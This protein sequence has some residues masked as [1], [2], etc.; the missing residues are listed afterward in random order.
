MRMKRGINPLGF[1]I[2]E[3]MIFL[4]V[5]GA[6]VLVGLTAISGTQGRSEF[7]VAVNDAQQQID[8]VINNVTNGYYA[9]TSNISCRNIGNNTVLQPTP[10][11]AGTN[12]DCSFLGRVIW[13]RQSPAPP[14]MVVYSVAGIR[15]TG[16]VDKKEVVSMS[17]ADPDVIESSREE[18]LLKNGLTIGSVSIGAS[19]NIGAVGFFTSFGS[20]TS[21]GGLGSS[22]SKYNFAGLSGTTTST[23]NIRASINDSAFRNHYDNNN[24]NF[25]KNPNDGIRVCLLGG[26]N[27]R[28]YI[29]IGGQGKLATTTLSISPGSVCP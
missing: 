25:G 6:L 13:F 5:S 18:I 29:T 15:Q 10:S 22:S 9:D 16:G 23:D 28:A 27:Q 24:P 3:T 20:Y 4:A 14:A 26:D 12:L 19:P 8:K 1:T 21:S 11:V 17:E 2:V 7:R